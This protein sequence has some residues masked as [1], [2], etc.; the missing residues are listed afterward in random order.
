MSL[1]NDLLSKISGDTKALIIINEYMLK[2]IG[3]SEIALILDS[4]VTSDLERLGILEMIKR[5]APQRGLSSADTNKLVVALS[6]TEESP[7]SAPSAQ[8]APQA[9]SIRMHRFESPEAA[10]KPASTTETPTF[11]VKRIDTMTVRRDTKPLPAANITPRDIERKTVFYGGD[12]ALSTLASE[13]L[14]RMSERKVLIADDDGRVR[15]IFKKKLEDNNFLVTEATD[16]NKA[17]ELL[18]QDDYAVAVLD[19]KMPGLHGLELLGRLSKE[20]RNKHIPVIICSA[21]EQLQQEFVISAYPN[22]RYLVKPVPMDKLA[23][24]VE[25]LSAIKH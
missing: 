21:Y 8:P 12:S 5:L 22:I 1:N 20:C 16:G 10:S 24:T 25:E 18:E 7:L 4:I 19:M 14:R 23:S 6:T 2:R 13:G 17:W 11:K 15:M 9:N 3:I